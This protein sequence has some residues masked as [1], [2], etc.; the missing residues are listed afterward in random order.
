MRKIMLCLLL[1]S[2]LMVAQARGDVAQEMN[3]DL[4]LSFEDTPQIP[5]IDQIAL[6][7]LPTSNLFDIVAAEAIQEFDRVAALKAEP[8]FV[9]DDS[10]QVGRSTS[11]REV[12][13][14]GWTR[15]S[16]SAHGFGKMTKG[17]FD[18]SCF[19]A[20]TQAQWPRVYT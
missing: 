1:F 15:P 2:L 4:V 6:L 14:K 7:D 5:T 11:P 20:P 8:W 18:C 17:V 13:F 9:S 10:Q 12:S 16:E 3:V 19:K